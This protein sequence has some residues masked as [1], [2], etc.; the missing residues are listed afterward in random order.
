MLENNE[1]KHRPSRSQGPGQV[2][3][4]RAVENRIRQPKE[5]MVWSPD[6]GSGLL[7]KLNGDLLVQGYI[8]DKIFMKIC[9]V[10]LSGDISQ[11]VEKCPVSQC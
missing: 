6:S 5:N 7:P 2:Q 4:K 1:A 3:Y 9:M 8:C 10:T 11:I